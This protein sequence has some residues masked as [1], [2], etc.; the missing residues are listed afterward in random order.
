VPPASSESPYETEFNPFRHDS[1]WK[2]A[3]PGFTE[4]QLDGRILETVHPAAVPAWVGAI[5]LFLAI[6][7]MPYEFYVLLRLVVPAMAIWVCTIAGGQKKT[8]CVVVFTLAAFLWNPLMPIELPRG[9]WAFPDIVG[10]ILFGVAA[11]QMP[12]S[13]PSLHKG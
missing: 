12:A 9:A 2:P 13:K 4:Q 1:I 6:L 10:A 8:G 5:A 11:A 3:A 7:S